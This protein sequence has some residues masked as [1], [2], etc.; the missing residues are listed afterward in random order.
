MFER[1]LY[2]LLYVIVGSMA[3]LT[4]ANESQANS[5]AWMW[6]LIGLA[7]AIVHHTYVW[8]G[9]RPLSTCY[10]SCFLKNKTRRPSGGIRVLIIVNW[11]SPRH[12]HRTGHR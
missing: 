4:L 10:H 7:V 2:Q 9:L 1:Q 12:S 3:V 5:D 6:L 11:W 8:F